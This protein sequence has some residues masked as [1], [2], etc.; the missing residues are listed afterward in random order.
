MQSLWISAA[1]FFVVSVGSIAHFM[2][3]PPHA[4]H[5]IDVRAI[6]AVRLITDSDFLGL[7]LT[8]FLVLF[9]STWIPIPRI[10]KRPGRA[11]V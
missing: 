8:F 1:V 9:F 2:L 10:D 11:V 4:R 7:Q 5:M 3:F 6:T